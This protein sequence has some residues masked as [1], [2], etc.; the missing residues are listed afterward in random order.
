[1]KNDESERKEASGYFEA[2]LKMLMKN[3]EITSY[4]ELAERLGVD[5]RTLYRWKKDPRKMGKINVAG[6]KSIMEYEDKDLDF[7]C[8]IFKLNTNLT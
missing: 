4:D 8:K 3:H 1:M 7:L 2:W 5:R 6:I